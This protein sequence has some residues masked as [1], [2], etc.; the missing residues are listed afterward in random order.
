MRFLMLLTQLY[1]NIS[2]TMRLPNAI[3]TTY[4]ALLENDSIY[5][6]HEPDAFDHA[7]G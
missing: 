6:H 3:I 2:R 1:T 7:L 4:D 5:S